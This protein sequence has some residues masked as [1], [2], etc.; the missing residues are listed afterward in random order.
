MPSAFFVKCRPHGV[1]ARE[2]ALK[3][4]RVFIGYAPWMEGSDQTFD[5]HN[6][7]RSILDL[8]MEEGK[9]PVARLHE[10]CRSPEYQRQVSK[11]QDFAKSVE[12]DSFVVLP[13]PRLGSCWIGRTDGRFELVDD[14]PWAEEFIQ[15]ARETDPDDDINDAAL[16][17]DV[18][19]TWAVV[20]WR[21]VV[22]IRFP[23]WLSYSF[24]SRMT[25]G[26]IP[27]RPD[28]GA[29]ALD[30]L[31]RL[32]DG[33]YKPEWGPTVNQVKIQERLLDWITP[34]MLEHLSCELLQLEFPDLRWLHVGGTGDGGV[35]GLAFDRDDRVAAVLQCKWKTEDDPAEIGRQLASSA[36]GGQLGGNAFVVTLYHRKSPSP[37]PA[38]VTILDREDLA[39]MLIKHRRATTFSSFLRIG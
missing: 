6:I 18:V 11:N 39:R 33:T 24:L 38:G 7:R 23:R 35:D 3:Y 31:E 13:R 28:G 19:Q 12:P 16:V 2:L 37:A 36:V 21:E 30:V 34:S 17:G 25:V 9:I 14:P 1:D 32:Y 10:E 8:S 5:R 20:S 15:T 4:K 26:W 29:A 27:D 22:F